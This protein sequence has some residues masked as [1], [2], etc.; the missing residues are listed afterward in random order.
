M[1]TAVRWR[2]PLCALALLT[3]GCGNR[4]SRSEILAANEV[5]GD[6]VAVS[7]GE[8]PAG[9]G[10]DSFTTLVPNVEGGDGPVVTATPGSG[11][12]ASPGTPSGPASRAPIVVGL[13]NNETGI[14]ANVTLPVRQV[15]QAWARSVNQKGGINGHPIQLLVADCANNASL[16]LPSARD[17]VEKQG[18][19]ALAFECSEVA[20]LPAYVKDKR[21]PLVGSLVGY[22]DWNTNPMLFPTM[23]NST[24]N[25]AA[26]GLATKE[27][28]LK[29]VAILYCVESPQCKIG[30]DA[31]AAALAKVWG[32]GRV[33]G[34]DNSPPT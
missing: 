10:D 30:S 25:A 7:A 33:P 8:A 18:A 14:G 17:L 3:A 12:P 28:G 27:L 9:D 4:L 11:E 16:N 5:G 22:P 31:Y 21:V 1:T 34:G 19:I 20:G 13:I 26:T 6:G 24:G 2:V 23:P 15:W 32:G 29:K